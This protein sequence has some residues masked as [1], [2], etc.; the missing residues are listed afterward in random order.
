VWQRALILVL[1]SIGVAVGQGHCDLLV[2]AAVDSE[3]QPVLAALEGGK[4]IHIGAWTFWRGKI[5]R[6]SVVVSRTQ[7]GPVNAVAATVLG[8]EHYQPAAILNYGT[9]GAHRPDL[10]LWDVILG[11]KTTDYSAYKTQHGDAGSGVRLER[12]MPD[13][14]ALT[15]RPNVVTRFVSFPGNE[16]LI[17]AALKIRNPRGRVLRGNLGSAHQF[18]REIDMLTWLNKTFG[19][20]SEDMESA[21]AHGAAIAFGTPFLG[22]RMISDSEWHHRKFER[23]AGRYCGEFVLEL[24]R[25]LPDTTW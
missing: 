11:E 15:I 2:Q 16:R 24:I 9:A 21:Y 22:I 12:R 10:Q 8:I 6:K 13:S 1:L 17:A 25:S 18:N 14:Y 5:G 7:V 23:V 3:L 20:D 19:T 4:R